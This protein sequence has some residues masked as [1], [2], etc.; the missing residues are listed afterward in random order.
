MTASDFSSLSGQNGVV[1]FAEPIALWF[2]FGLVGSCE[3]VSKSPE[4]ESFLRNLVV[5]E[6]V[7]LI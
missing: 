5:L 7:F 6:S 2:G 4:S 3:R 1:A